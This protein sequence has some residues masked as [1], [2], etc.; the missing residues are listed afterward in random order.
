MKTIIAGPRNYHEYSTI[1]EAVRNAGIT[2]TEVVSG[3]ATGGDALGERWA[4]ENGIPVKEFPAD[5][6]AVGQAAG[7]G[8][9]KQMVDY[10]EALVAVWDGESKSIGNMIKQARAAKLLVHVQMVEPAAD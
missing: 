4:A 7:P 9:H 8:S 3:K 6:E 1:C 10:A 2:I 5:W